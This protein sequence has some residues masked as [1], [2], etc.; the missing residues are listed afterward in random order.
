MGGGGSHEVHHYHTEYRVPPETQ[1]VLDD[2]TK[3]LEEVEKEAMERSDPQLFDQNSKILMNTFIDQLAKLQLTDVIDKKTGEI[4]I[5]FIGSISAGKTSLIN[6]LFTKNLPVALG[7]CTAKCEVVH[8]EN[9]NIVWDV[10]GQNDDYKFYKPE[11]LSFV[12]DLDK[13][14][15]VFDNDISMIS[16]FLKVV[17]KINPNNL[18]IVRTKVDQ[19]NIQHIRTI[20]EEKVLDKQ[21]VKE[22]LGIDVEVY[23][24]SSHA[25][26]NNCEEKYDWN[27]LR[28]ELGLQY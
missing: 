1:K 2:Q 16:N 28:K 20:D 25:I 19:H 13:C 21:K 10:C 27:A 6:A 14:V 4:H 7:H 17:H 9:H 24:I 26:I 3:K 12:K 15:V 8:S 23:C 18:I 22:L 11:N 5:G